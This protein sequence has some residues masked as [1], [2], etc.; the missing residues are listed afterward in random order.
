MKVIQIVSAAT[1]ERYAPVVFPSL[2]D[3]YEELVNFLQAPA[4]DEARDTWA[5][6]KKDYFLVLTEKLPDSEVMQFSLLP[7]M[8]IEHL[9]E[10]FKNGADEPSRPFSG[11]CL[12]S[13]V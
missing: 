1:G 11:T 9:F 8:T 7:M 5:E 6:M 3:F 10:L 12:N 2:K 4:E 13:G